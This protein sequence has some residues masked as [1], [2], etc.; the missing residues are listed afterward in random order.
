MPVQNLVEAQASRAASADLSLI[1]DME[2]AVRSYCRS[3]PVVFTRAQG[4]CIFDERGNRYIDFLCAAGSLNYGHNDPLIKQALIRYLDDDGILQ[5]LDFATAAKARFLQEFR[6]TILVPR[7]LH[8]RVQFTGPTGTNCVEAAIKLARKVTGRRAIAAFTNSYHG[9]SLGALALTGNRAKRSAA[10]VSLGDTL[11]LPYDAYFGPEIDTVGLA[12]KL[13]LD[14]SSGY[15]A[16]AAFIVEAVQGE[17]GLN[18][19]RDAWMRALA[20]LAKDLGALLIVDDIQAGCGR[21]G[22]FFSFEAM[23]IHPDIVCL[24][25]SIGGS[26]LPMALTLIHPKLDVWEP[27]EHNGTFRGNNLAFVGATAAL[28]YWRDASFQNGIAHRSKLLH[29]ALSRITNGYMR[30]HATPVGRGLFVGL[31]FD[32]P[33]RSEAFR[34]GL[35]V[36]GVLTETCGPND[37]VVK[38]MP[39]LNIPEDTLCEAVRQIEACA[40]EMAQ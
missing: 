12:R 21:C 16:P 34:R 33:S 3:T 24:S 20:A 23:D 11:R 28:E 37:E 22:T 8:Y 30:G 27:G 17:G 6:D 35:L 39:A 5:T 9:V 25:K 36:R 26:G 13:F 38:F 29:D 32:S 18:C 10:G 2:S 1:E 7:A 31:R 4:S 14:A 19:A 40:A 15:D